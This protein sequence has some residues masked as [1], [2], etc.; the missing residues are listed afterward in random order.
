MDF[1][2]KHFLQNYFQSSKDNLKVE[3]SITLT[4]HEVQQSSRDGVQAG[5]VRDVGARV[6]E[7]RDHAVGHG[8]ALAG[9]V[10][11]EAVGRL[12]ERRQHDRLVRQLHCAENLRKDCIRE[13]GVF[14]LRSM[15]LKLIFRYSYD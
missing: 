10:V 13:L 7:D 1:P 2:S 3:T 4:R 11:P 9:Q 5:A 14:C 6:A 8:P 15:V 12:H